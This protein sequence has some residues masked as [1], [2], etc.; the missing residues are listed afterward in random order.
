MKMQKIFD[1]I[2]YQKCIK[3]SLKIKK[4]LLETRKCPS[5]NEFGGHFRRS[6]M[7]KLQN[8][9]PL[10]RV[11]QHLKNLPIKNNQVSPPNR[12]YFA[13]SLNDLFL[14]NCLK[15]HQVAVFI[16]LRLCKTKIC[17]QGANLVILSL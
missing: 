9:R 6:L 5:Y 8:F 17:V 16:F 10:R 13:T 7:S 3:N 12:K 14:V 15:S 4:F 11:S 1:F 2:N